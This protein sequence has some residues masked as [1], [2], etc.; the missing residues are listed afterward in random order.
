MQTL[1]TTALTTALIVGSYLMVPAN[2][3][4]LSMLE[5][6]RAECAQLADTQMLGERSVQRIN[7]IKDCLID[8]GFNSR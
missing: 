1:L 5:I 3:A 2:A 4:T 6:A 8:R 7:F